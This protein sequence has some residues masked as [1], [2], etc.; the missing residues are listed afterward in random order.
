[1]WL[2][3][4]QSLY[5]GTG[6]WAGIRDREHGRIHAPKRRTFR[7]YKVKV[8]GARVALLAYVLCMRDRIAVVSCCFDILLLIRFDDLLLIRFDGLLL[9]RFCGLLRHLS[10][11]MGFTRRGYDNVCGGTLALIRRTATQGRG[12][13]DGLPR[14]R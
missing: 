4:C 12:S 5:H 6:V 14:A 1:M 13:P 8:C 3:R 10:P 7:L 9:H 11:S 2:K